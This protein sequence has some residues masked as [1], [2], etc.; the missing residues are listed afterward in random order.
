MNCIDIPVCCVCVRVCVCGART[1]CYYC[2]QKHGRLSSMTSAVAVQSGSASCLQKVQIGEQSQT[3]FH[4]IC[5]ISDEI[6]QEI[7]KPF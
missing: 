5:G 2:I 3:F 4:V 1:L 6:A 7:Q